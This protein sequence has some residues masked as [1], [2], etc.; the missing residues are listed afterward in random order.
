[1]AAAFCRDLLQRFQRS[2]PLLLTSL[3]TLNVAAQPRPGD[4]PP[5]GG[6]GGGGGGNRER[7]VVTQFDEDKDGR[8]NTAERALAVDYIIAN[9]VGR[10]GRGGGGGRGG[11]RP[12]ASPGVKLT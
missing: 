9:P 4:G 7:A 3:L 10:G 1:C 12:P 6:P 8:L 11:N 2:W 5:P